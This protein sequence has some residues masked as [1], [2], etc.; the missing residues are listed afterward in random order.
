MP[1]LPLH[2]D[3]YPSLVGK[4]RPIRQMNAKLFRACSVN[5]LQNP[6]A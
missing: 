2:T 4:R 6:T 1:A 3:R 5:A